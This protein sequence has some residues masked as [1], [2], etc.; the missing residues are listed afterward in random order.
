LDFSLPKTIQPSNRHNLHPIGQGGYA[1]LPASGGKIAPMSTHVEFIAKQLKVRPNQV[2]ATIQLLDDGN[3]IPF[4]SR[5][6][7]EMTATL[8][9]E[10]VRIIAD[11]LARLRS[12]EG[13]RT[14]ASMAREKGLTG[15]AVHILKQTLTRR[16]LEDLVKES[17]LSDQIQTVEEALQGGRD[18][19]AETISEHATVRQ[20]T[21]DNPRRNAQPPPGYTDHHW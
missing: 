1:S 13:R 16:A 4:I 7:K 20:I 9:D 2:E 12:L 15:L 8:N 19:A 11:E 10:H 6:R 21:A 5:Y 17:Y 18:I 14:R 3:T